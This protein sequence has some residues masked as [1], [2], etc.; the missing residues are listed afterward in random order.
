MFM[1]TRSMVKLD[2][3]EEANQMGA[4]VVPWDL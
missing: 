4:L 2:L 3:S 1:G